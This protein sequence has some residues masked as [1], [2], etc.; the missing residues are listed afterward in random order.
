[1]ALQHDHIEAPHLGRSVLIAPNRRINLASAGHP[2]ATVK[3][4]TKLGAVAL[5]LS[6]QSSIATVQ[7]IAT[8]TYVNMLTALAAPNITFT[9][10]PP[11]TQGIT[12]QQ[13]Q[14]AY[15]QFVQQL[16]L[17]QGQA[18]E[19]VA[20]SGS[21]GGASILSNLVTVAGTI[22]G[23]NPTVQSDF[24]LLQTLKPGSQIWQSTLN[25]TTALVS[26]EM[27]P[28]A[29]LKTQ[30]D[31][32]SANL[33]TAATTLT[34]AAS[35]GVLAQLQTA[36][37]NE[38]NALNKDISNCNDKISSDNAKI[39]GLGFAAGASIVVGIIGLLNFWN[40]IG[41]LMI[42]GGVAGAYFAIAEIEVLKGEIAR[43]NAEIKNDTDTINT[44]QTAAQTVAS[45]A[46]SAQAAANLNSAAQQELN[47][48]IQL[49][50]TLAADLSAAV[51]DLNNDDITDALNEWN[52]VVSAS[53]FL[54]GITAYIWPSSIQLA[55]PTN[56]S[57]TGNNAYLVSN[58]GM[59]YQFAKGGNTWTALPN[60]SLSTIA[61]GGTVVG[62]DGAPANGT[63]LQPTPY[64]QSF[65]A[66]TYS[67]SSSAW[68]NIST[69]PAAQIATDGSG[70]IWAINQTVSD[71]QAYKYNGSGTGWTAVGKMPNND[72]PGSIAAYKGT[73]F[74]LA[75]NGSGLWYASSSGWKQI[76]AATYS[77]LTSNGSWLGLIDSSGNSWAINAQT[78]GSYSPTA[79][80]T[81]VSNLAQAPGGD[82]YAVDTNLNLWHVASGNAGSTQ[83]RSNCVGVTV[84][85]T[86][87]VYA[88]DNTGNIWTLTNLGS[89]SWQQLP[90]LPTN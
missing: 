51:Q 35:T 73:L 83:L 55:N 11:G 67:A 88:I 30:I 40:P 72:A 31:T 42:G 16:A 75:N 86:G 24:T 28:L 38:I 36:Y 45:F 66:K 59:V 10:P 85:D 76:G 27:A 23:I 69:F 22:A 13:L 5:N 26:A 64:G 53:A 70:A 18:Q 77:R 71:R 32:L 34:T 57:A 20:T 3:P 9:A 7:I 47:T 4:K 2:L 37:Q 17:L 87:I 25:Q 82:Q 49:C 90:A 46:Q 54:G 80:M 78:V 61:A 6:V 19:W 21:S 89:N 74:A 44:D 58:S 15:Q 43:L 68:T 12:V 48:L 63:Q 39:V 52:E 41:W 81:G 56:L 65:H 62:I 79:M 60:Y 8:T 14:T 33:N 29:S 1:M 84:S 50:G